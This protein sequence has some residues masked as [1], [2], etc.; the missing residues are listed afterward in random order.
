[1][2]FSAVEQGLQGPPFDPF[3]L[4]THLKI[5]V[6]ARDDVRDART[7]PAA[8]GQVVIEFNPS[9]PKARLRYSIA[10]ELAHTL[11]PDCV[12]RIRNRA[13][14]AE[15]QHHDAELELLCNIGAAELLMPIG[16]FP[17]LQRESLSIDHLLD[18]R[19]VYDVSTEAILLRVVKLTPEPCLVFSAVRS[20][21]SGGGRY[22]LEYAV[23]SRSW[24]GNVPSGNFF[25][26]GSVVEQCTAIG[27]TA[28]GRED[29]PNQ[30]GM[31]HVEAVGIPPYPGQS[32]PRVAGIITP[33]RVRRVESITITEVKGD[34][35]E[36]R[37]AGQKLI[38]HIVNDRGL[39]WG[40]GFGLAVR[41]KWPTVQEDFRR[42]ALAHHRQFKLGAVHISS[43]SGD[44]RICHMVA[45]HGYGP[46]PRP[47]IRYG[48]LRT[49]LSSLANEA[50]R[51]GA[52]VHMPR[53]GTGEAH[54]S[55]WIISEMID[56]AL[57]Q[58]GTAV[59]VYDLPQRGV[60]SPG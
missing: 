1:V 45:Q 2:I 51:G 49:C 60:H 26:R 40:A 16:S 36:P 44:T 21:D 50:R 15:M 31:V 3:D 19:R 12:E 58:Q 39:T 9:R 34:A 11:F 4:A 14:R 27:F 22:Q 25:R 32:Y 35:T 59:T 28:K 8:S 20:D 5:P 13:L 7:V 29:G 54:G 33:A 6:V 10:H 42:W 17:E 38:G 37:G 43:I 41:R 57:C 55:W 30:L 24:R 53:I 18:L 46:S 48:A 52:T 47:R 56:E 23:P